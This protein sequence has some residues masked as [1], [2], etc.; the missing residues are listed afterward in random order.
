MI[1]QKLEYIAYF[2]FQSA[3]KEWQICAVRPQYMDDRQMIPKLVLIS[4]SF[5]LFMFLFVP[6]T[7]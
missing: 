7:F 2:E 5:F 3:F 6:D 1:Q 4:I